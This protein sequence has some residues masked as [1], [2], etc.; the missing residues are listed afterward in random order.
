MHANTG[1]HMTIF[2]ISEMEARL[3]G[4]G[5]VRIHR[6]FI[7]SLPHVDAFTATSVEIS[8]RVVPISR[9]YRVAALQVLRK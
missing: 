8:S 6:S 9:T 7:V 1:M 5:F 2:R 4:G 3:A